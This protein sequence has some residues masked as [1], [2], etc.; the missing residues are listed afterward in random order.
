[1]S[2]EPVAPKLGF[3]GSTRTHTCSCRTCISTQEILALHAPL[4]RT[5]DEVPRRSQDELAKFL[6]V[7]VFH[8]REHDAISNLANENLC[9]GQ[10]TF[11]GQPHGLAATGSE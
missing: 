1:M 6:V 11:F 10:P 5:L 9:S 3:C 7:L 4:M 8:G 2:P